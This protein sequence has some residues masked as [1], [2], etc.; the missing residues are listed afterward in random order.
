M[1]VSGAGAAN[2]ALQALQNAEPTKAKLQMSMLKK[3]LE[4]EKDQSAELLK[5]IEGKGRMVDIRV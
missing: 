5:L 1:E 4:T 2:G 3:A